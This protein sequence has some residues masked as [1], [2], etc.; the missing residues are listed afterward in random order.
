MS[1]SIDCIYGGVLLVAWAVLPVSPAAAQWK[2]VPGPLATK[3]AAEV[4]PETAHREYPRPQMVRKHW[5]NLNG[6]W[7][8]AIAPRDAEGDLSFER[9]ILVPFPIESSL[10]GV[11]KHLRTD[12]VLYYRRTFETPKLNPGDRLLLHFGAVDWQARVQVNGKQI[13]EHTGGYDPF[14]FD[15]TANLKRDKP[16]QELTVAVT[17]PTD[18]SYQPRGKQV[19]KPEGIWYTPISGIW[20]T[21]WL[22]V[23]PAT[24]IERVVLLP[25]VDRSQLTV[26]VHLSGK[27][28]EG[29]V[30]VVARDGEKVVARQSG[31]ANKPLI[32]PLEDPKLWSP[33][34]PHLYD[35]QVTYLADDEKL[36]D[37]VQSYFAM[38][39][40]SLGKDDRGLTRILLNNKFLFQTGT[41]DQGYWPDGLYTPPTDAAMRYDLEVTKELGF[42]MVRKHVKVE[43]ARWYRYCDEL[44]LLVWQDMPSGDKS[45]GANDPD[46]TRSPESAEN[47]RQEWRAIIHDLHCFPCIVM[48][49][50]FNEGW[51]QFD[52]AAIV[53]YTRELDS[54][55]LINNASGWADRGVGDVRDVHIYPG[56]GAPP[57]EAERA[58]VLGEFGGLGLPLERHTWQS[59]DNWGYRSYQTREELNLAF[60]A[61][62]DR[63]PQLIAEGLS[64]S[65]YTQTTDVEIEVNGLLTYDRAEL[66][67]DRDVARRANESLFRR[68][69]KVD[70]VLATS[71]KQG[72]VWRYTTEKPADEWQQPRFDAS[73]WQEGQGGFGEKSTPGSVVRTEW[74]T[75][76]IWLRRTVKLEKRKWHRPLLRAHWDEDTEVYFNGKLAAKMAGYSTQYGRVSLTK[77][78]EAELAEGGELVIAVHTHQTGGGQYIDL[79]LVDVEEEKIVESGAK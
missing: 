17:D 43:P 46:L 30:E 16:R 40:I 44:G 38:R 74:T 60:A 58:I 73:S 41:L 76:D 69:V 56:P 29:R 8:F 25:D 10:S 52:T 34:Q 3:W 67:I 26:R 71:E 27:E 20:Q 12:D 42:N 50:P 35:L 4:T 36:A 31:A 7:D 15:I 54:T 61:L 59:K 75:P 72:Q 39:K 47:Y 70:E 32:L 24:Y 48:W 77:A 5:T 53:D 64:A 33:Q 11:M 49:V 13:G 9:Q 79:G 37:E 23:V 21:V 1:R 78:G 57:D 55:R 66:K 63:M 22:E 68:I 51:G 6:L 14:T 65:V 2:P 18:T 19:L 45:I 62:Y 28:Q